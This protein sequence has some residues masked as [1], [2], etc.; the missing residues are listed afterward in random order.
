[1]KICPSP[2]VYTFKNNDC[3]KTVEECEKEE[4]LINFS[5]ISIY[6]VNNYYDF[7]DRDN[8][9][10]SYLSEA[11]EVLPYMN[12]RKSIH[13]H[14]QKH[15]YSINE[16]LFQFGR[17]DKTKNF[18]TIENGRLDYDTQMN[19]NL[20][21]VFSYYLNIN[22]NGY[23]YKTKLMPLSQILSQ[24]FVLFTILAIFLYSFTRI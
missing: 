23:V 6:I 1:M 9:V 8:P 15:E 21:P 18:Y 11:V 20:Y 22:P 16:N 14:V 2:L 4:E 12:R 17:K 3:T 24:A 19:S 7:E 10:K 13:S 5:K